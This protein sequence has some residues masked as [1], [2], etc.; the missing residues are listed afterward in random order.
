VPIG[1][2]ADLEVVA[3]ACELTVEGYVSQWNTSMTLDH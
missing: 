3:A 1:L 2:F